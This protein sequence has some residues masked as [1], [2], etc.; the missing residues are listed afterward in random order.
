MTLRDLFAGR[1]M[2]GSIS[3]GALQRIARE[4]MSETT[5]SEFDA[6]KISKITANLLASMVYEIADAMLAE[7]EKGAAK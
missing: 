1:A 5:P 7:R 6:K 3:N 4:V 2:Q